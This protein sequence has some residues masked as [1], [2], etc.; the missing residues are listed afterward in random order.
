MESSNCK[1]VR[2][3]IEDGM[4]EVGTLLL[5]FAPLDAALGEGKQDHT[6]I[7]LLFLFFG[8]LLFGGALV[9]EWRRNRV[10]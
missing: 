9:L 6:L 10:S 4:R 5:A 8:T 7:L 2:E 3:R 1:S